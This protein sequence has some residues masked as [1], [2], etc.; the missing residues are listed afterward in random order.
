MANTCKSRLCPVYGEH[1][2]V[3]GE[4]TFFG[5][6]T[7]CLLWDFLVVS[8]CTPWPAKNSRQ[9]GMQI[10]VLQKHPAI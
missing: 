8:M 4:P 9:N 7:L 6:T 2:L 3:Q 10:F 1:P 5:R